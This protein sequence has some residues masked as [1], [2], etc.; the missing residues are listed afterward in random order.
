MEGGLATV[1]LVWWSSK[2]SQLHSTSSAEADLAQLE[3]TNWILYQDTRPLP[4]DKTKTRTPI[5]DLLVLYRTP[6]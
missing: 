4:S 5:Y 3:D 2:V 6:S 1:F